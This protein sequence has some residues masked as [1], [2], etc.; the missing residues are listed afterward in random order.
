MRRSNRRTR[1]RRRSSRMSV[2][3]LRR[4]VL[5]ESE[6]LTGELEP[7]ENVEAIEIDADEYAEELEQDLDIY[8]ALKIQEAKLQR[9]HKQLVREAKKVRRNKALAKK[10]ILRRLK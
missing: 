2:N 7:I 8:K 6:K 3:E 4:F 1:S 9:R 10:R 5:K